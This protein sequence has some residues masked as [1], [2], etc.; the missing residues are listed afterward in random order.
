MTHD[1]HTTPSNA[2]VVSHG[3][4]VVR[5]GGLMKLST[6]QERAYAALKADPKGQLTSGCGGNFKRTTMEALARQRLV[7]LAKAIREKKVKHRSGH[8]STVVV[9]DWTAQLNPAMPGTEEVA[10]LDLIVERGEKNLL[11]KQRD[12]AASYVA[13]VGPRVALEGAP[14]KESGYSPAAAYVEHLAMDTNRL[15]AAYTIVR[16]MTGEVNITPVP[17]ADT[18][19]PTSIW[20]IMEPG[21]PKKPGR[22]VCRVRGESQNAASYAANALLNQRGG[23]DMRRLGE[24]EVGCWVK[25]FRVR[26]TVLRMES[27]GDG[28]FRVREVSSGVLVS[29]SDTAK[30]AEESAVAEAGSLL[31]AAAKR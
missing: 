23:Y 30:A 25:D 18:G 9:I 15:L 20:K 2:N 21:T 8:T 5:K 27:P 6:A 4:V 7:T 10:E 14:V 28:T 16:S 31:S 11:P 17:E 12:Q 19:A 24:K 13:V 29:E 3:N 22:E 1:L 26:G